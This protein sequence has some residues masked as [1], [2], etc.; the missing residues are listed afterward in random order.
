MDSFLQKFFEVLTFWIT[1]FVFLSILVG[2]M[3]YLVERI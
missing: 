1:V 2:F 3:L